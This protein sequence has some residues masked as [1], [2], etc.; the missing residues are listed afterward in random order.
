MK[1]FVSQLIAF[2]ALQAA[3]GAAIFASYDIDR[4]AYIA[5]AQ[6][7]QARL[8]SLGS[9]KVVLL[10]GSSTA[11]GFDSKKIQEALGMPVVNM[12]I[13]ASLG[14]NYLLD[15]SVDS[16]GKGDLVVV[17]LE[18]PLYYSRGEAALTIY[19]LLEQ[20]PS[21]FSKFTYD[22]PMV[23]TLLDGGHLYVRHVLRSVVA[24]L[25]PARRSE[26]GLRRDWHDETGDVVKHRQLPPRPFSPERPGYFVIDEQVIE[27]LAALSE[28]CDQRGAR[29]FVFHPAV[30]LAEESVDQAIYQPIYDSIKESTNVVQ[31]NEPKEMA[32]DRKLFFDSS[33]HVNAEGLEKRTSLLIQRLKAALKK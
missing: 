6:D 32:Y 23:K 15:E 3:I 21:D 9:P 16:I 25:F 19:Q 20:R 5:A 28:L 12:G 33:Y 10:G 26:V 22:Y 13:Q 31:L 2:W 14:V 30:A 29:L 7:K 1:P 4:G 17:S 8:E 11:F 27:R 24:D 18:Y